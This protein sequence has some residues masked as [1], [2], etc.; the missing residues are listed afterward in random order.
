M[1]PQGG[2][3]EEDPLH[4]QQHNRNCS[5]GHWHSKHS[6]LRTGVRQERVDGEE[7]EDDA[8][9]SHQGAR[10]QPRLSGVE[11][12][13]SLAGDQHE[14]LREGKYHDELQQPDRAHHALKALTNASERV[15]IKDEVRQRRMHQDVAEGAVALEEQHSKLVSF[16]C[17]PLEWL[18]QHHRVEAQG[19]DLAPA[20][21]EDRVRR[22]D[23]AK[24]EEDGL[25]RDQPPRHERQ[26]RERGRQPLL[27][28]PTAA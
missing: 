15:H 26:A 11:Q 27:G 25:S 12:E 28:P 21:A 23:V 5:R 2:E 19:A 13:E 4:R 10:Q 18:Q 17:W 14:R 8:R 24:E 16:A 9:K 22:Y 1:P 7:R 3:R 6:N 20:R